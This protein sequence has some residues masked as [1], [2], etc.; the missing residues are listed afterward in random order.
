MNFEFWINYDLHSFPGVVPGIKSPKDYQSYRISTCDSNRLV[1]IFDST[2]G[3][4]SLTC[5]VEI[6]DVSGQT[7]P[8]RHQ[9]ALEMFFILKGEGV[10]ICDGKKYLLKLEIVY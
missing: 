4:A 1:I 5:C 2:N 9:W 3:N 7:S 6:F 10:D 8:N